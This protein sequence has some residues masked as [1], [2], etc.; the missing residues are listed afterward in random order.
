MSLHAMSGIYFVEFT[1]QVQ[2]IITCF[3]VGGEFN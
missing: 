2:Q 1:A 3:E